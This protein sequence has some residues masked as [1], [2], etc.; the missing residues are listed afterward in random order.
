MV[1]RNRRRQPLY[2]PLV[3]S[4]VEQLEREF[5]ARHG[6]AGGVAAGFG[7]AALGLALDAAAVR[8]GDVLLPDFV[9]AQ[10][11]EAV[12]RAGGTPV[13]YPVGR[14]LCVAPEEFRGAFTPA[15]RAAV[16]VHYFGRSQPSVASLTEIC[17]ERRVS[18]IEDCALALGAPDAGCHGD[19]ALFS[20]TKS[21]WCYGGGLLAARSTELI[22][23]AKAL[24][25]TSFH[26]AP[27]LALR[28]GWLRRADFDANHPEWSRAAE[29][30]GRTLETFSGLRARGFYDSGRY[31]TLL[32]GFA[33]RRAR[34]LLAELPATTAER[35]RIVEAICD[36]LGPARRLLFRPEASP[37]DSCS[38]LLLRSELG[39]AFA[40]RERAASAGITLRLC[41]P[42]Y[43]NAA[44]AQTSA[45]LS[46][47]AEHLLL[48]EIPPKLTKREVNRIVRCLQ[49][50]AAV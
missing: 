40:W 20:F 12:R 39:Q 38:F 50:L 2:N 26:A 14:D 46:W 7:R 34:R 13:F 27:G 8:G 28:Y 6:F 17:R 45:T 3:S 19:I 30:A 11:S 15:T 49:Q 21:D 22:A 16:A 18:F 24:R 32:P 23:R 31:D 1:S 33:A 47:L 29:F 35:R 25:E 4:A 42:A 48:M 44:P 9:C 5:A 37:Q 36:S 43:Q 10:V 41:W